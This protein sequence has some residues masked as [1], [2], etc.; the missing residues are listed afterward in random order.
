MKTY[1]TDAS[2]RTTQAFRWVFEP[3]ESLRN[4]CVCRNQTMQAL[5][6]GSWSPVIKGLHGLVAIED[7]FGKTKAF[8][9]PQ[10]NG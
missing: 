7:F 6:D 5:D 4:V 3:S 9:G 2:T 1:E 8:I 10:L